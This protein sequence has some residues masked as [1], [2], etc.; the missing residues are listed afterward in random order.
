MTP[1]PRPTGVDADRQADS[2]TVVRDFDNNYEF[3]LPKEWTA[4]PLTKE[5]IDRIVQQMAE[6]DPEFAKLA[7]SMR[8]ADDNVL[9]LLGFN[10]DPKYV[11]AQN[12]TLFMLIAIPDK[13]VGSLPMAGVTAIIEDNTFTGSSDTTW[14]V[15]NNPHGVE[16]GVVQGTYKFVTPEGKTLKTKSKVIAFQANQKLIMI[17]FITPVQFGAEVLPGVDQIIDTIQL[18]TP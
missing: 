3:I 1:T 16:V 12:P 4:I 13:I 8:T 6:Q 5:D 14:D 17:Q 7:E 10:T 2:R 9:R 15:V 11:K 18:M